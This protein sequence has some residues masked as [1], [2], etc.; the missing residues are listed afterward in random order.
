MGKNRAAM[1]QLGTL[2][3]LNDFLTPLS[4]RRAPCVYFVRV[5]GFTEDL[6]EGVKGFYQ[7]ARQNGVIIDGRIAHSILVET[8]SDRG[9]GT[10]F[11]NED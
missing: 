7:E 9:I 8:L 10:M 3:K 6:P 11:V 1:F 4:Q 2:S 5:E